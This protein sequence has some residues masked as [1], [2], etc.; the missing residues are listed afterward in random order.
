M[1]QNVHCTFHD[2]RAHINP[3]SDT[4]PPIVGMIYP[5][6]IYKYNWHIFLKSE[7][8]YKYYKIYIC[9]GYILPTIRKNIC[10]WEGFCK[11]FGRR[12]GECTM[13][14]VHCTIGQIRGA[15]KKCPKAI[16]SLNLFQRPRY[17]VWNQ[18]F[19]PDPSKH[20]KHSH[21]VA[22]VS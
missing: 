4:F 16:C 21:P 12:V 3:P 13:Y 19:K 18:N 10:Q 15:P 1:L 7:Y 20:F 8:K 11:P 5:I 14:S 6:P 2:S 9:I 17:V 22:K